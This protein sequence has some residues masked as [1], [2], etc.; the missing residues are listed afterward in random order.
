M[1]VPQETVLSAGYQ[2]MGQGGLRGDTLREA[3]VLSKTSV[4]WEY[5]VP[6]K[7]LFLSKHCY[8]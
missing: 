3:L 4:L 2:N 1:G 6:W 8:L 7:Y 5:S